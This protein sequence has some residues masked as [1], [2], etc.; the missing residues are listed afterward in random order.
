MGYHSRY[1]A[2]LSCLIVELRDASI[3]P[4]SLF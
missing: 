1:I 2:Q 4:R 3:L